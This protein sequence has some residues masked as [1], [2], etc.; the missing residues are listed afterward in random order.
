MFYELQYCCSNHVFLPLCHEITFLVVK[1]TDQFPGFSLFLNFNVRHFLLISVELFIKSIKTLLFWIL[2]LQ[3]FR[4]KQEHFFFFLFLP[5]PF[6]YM[7]GQVHIFGF[8]P[9]ISVQPFIYQVIYSYIFLKHRSI[10]SDPG[11][12]SSNSPFR[13]RAQ[14]FPQEWGNAGQRRR[15]LGVEGEGG[16]A[17]FS[18]CASV[19]RVIIMW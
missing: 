7:L 14:V 13:D 2:K 19:K 1:T 15:L 18:H 4:L 16:C 6:L 10:A 8:P 12:P 3:V 17:Q 9:V 11:A 5:L